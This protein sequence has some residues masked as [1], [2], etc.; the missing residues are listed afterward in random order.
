M[1]IVCIAWGWVLGALVNKHGTSDMTPV[2]MMGASGLMWAGVTFVAGGS[3]LGSV[4]VVV[5]A[6]MCLYVGVKQKFQKPTK[7]ME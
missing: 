3:G 4:F 1:R 7:L 6:I 2:G 5:A